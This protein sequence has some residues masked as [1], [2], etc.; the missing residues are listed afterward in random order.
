M[1]HYATEVCKCP[2]KFGKNPSLLII[3]LYF[4]LSC[5]SISGINCQILK[6]TAKKFISC[7]IFLHNKD[8]CITFFINLCYHTR[9]LFLVIA[10]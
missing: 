8:N 6:D 3:K 4:N 7:A 10:D 1:S 2:D 9:Q 5:H